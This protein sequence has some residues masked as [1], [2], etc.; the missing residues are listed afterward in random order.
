MNFEIKHG[1][2]L[3]AIGLTLML[4]CYFMNVTLFG[5]FYIIGAIAVGKIYLVYAGL[6][7]RKQST[8]GF[9][10]YGT[11]FKTLFMIGL[12]SGALGLIIG[13]VLFNNNEKLMTE[14]K[15]YKEASGEFGFKLGAVLGGMSEEEAALKAK[16]RKGE[17]TDNPMDFEDPFAYNLIPFN[18]LNIVIGAIF[19]ALIIAIFIKKSPS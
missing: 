17:P 4:A 1:L 11:A 14:F 19:W 10:D 2:I 3:A 15:E 16:E 18:L 7:K 13:P 6:L 9:L 12:I 5:S 8:D